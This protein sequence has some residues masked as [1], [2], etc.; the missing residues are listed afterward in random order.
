M[1][2]QENSVGVV[3]L[4]GFGE[5]GMNCLVIEANGRILVVDCGVMFP[6]PDEP[7][8]DV[9]HPSFEHL[10]AARD[11]IEG[12]ILTH[13]HEDHIAGVPYLLR[14]IDVPIYGSPYSLALVDRRL[15]ESDGAG[16]LVPRA[17]Q[18][19]GISEIGPFRVQSFPLPHS[20]AANTG[21]VIETAGR[22][23]LHTGD[24]KLG[25]CSMDRGQTALDRLAKMSEPGVDLMICDSTGAEETE[26]A[27]EEAVVETRLTELIRETSGA[28][29]VAIFSSNLTRMESLCNAAR[30]CGRR[31]V[32]A[33]RS[34]A[35]HTE[36]VIASG[37]LELPR[38]LLLSLEEVA[39]CG[40]D[41]LLVIVA[42]TQGEERSALGRIASGDH[43]LLH[44]E[45]GD[46][47]VLSSRFIPGNEIAISRMIDKLL[48]LGARVV[49]RGVDPEI[50]VSG[51]GSGLEIEAAVRAVKPRSFLAGHGTYRHLVAAAGIARSSGVERAIAVT[52]GTLVRLASTG[53]TIEEGY[54]PTG[55]VMIDG[56][57]GVPELAIRERRL[58]GAC[59]LLHVVWN[60]D[61][62]GTVAGEIEVIVR[63]VISEEA[64]PW[65]KAEVRTKV[66]AVL[67][68]LAPE[69]RRDTSSC[70]EAVRSALR[71]F[72]DKTIRREPYVIVTIL[73]GESGHGY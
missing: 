30:I 8:I 28:V 15:R 60:A 42:G 66:R 57:S 35:A 61:A 44:V 9:I 49:H 25:A 53:L 12:M 11:R 41:E 20:I 43:R 46:L 18:V 47:V 73:K 71:R 63:G 32:L 19:G 67:G 34:V 58:L 36:V 6:S 2:L 51:H 64:L 17:L 50:H 39:D 54:A 70:R 7:G 24:F 33:G 65:L 45:P 3:A 27:G 22:R 31:V 37:L 52:N 14:E 4:G 23:I 69:I 56:E 13:G 5:I 21:L 48:L 62:D 72:V 26:E 40:R 16:R 10:V 29:F 1:G 55:R 59:G 68:E 38:G